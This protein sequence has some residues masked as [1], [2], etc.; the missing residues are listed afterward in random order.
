MND[1]FETTYARH[2]E[3]CAKA[4]ELNKAVLFAALCRHWRHAHPNRI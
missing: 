2:K 3:L 1:D 4:N